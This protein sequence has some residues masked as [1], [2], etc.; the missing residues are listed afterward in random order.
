MFP[1]NGRTCLCMINDNISGNMHYR[2]YR[3]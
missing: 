2:Q 1:K 3:Q